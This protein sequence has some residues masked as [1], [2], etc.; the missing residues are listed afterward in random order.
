MTDATTFRRIF[1][2]LMAFVGVTWLWVVALIL[3]W[4]PERGTTWDP[5]FRLVATCAD[6]QACSVPFA[7]IA[8]L[9]KAGAF[10]ALKPPEPAGEVAEADAWL[11]WKTSTDKAWTYEATRSSWHFQTT[12]R[13]RFDGETPVLVEVQ[14]FDG[15]IFFYGMGLAMFSLIGLFLRGLRK[16]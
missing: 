2:W 13:Y 14:R 7:K 15:N 6:Q 8:E 9:R 10:T 12:V 16:Q 4:P 11:K 5:D 1:G 3:A